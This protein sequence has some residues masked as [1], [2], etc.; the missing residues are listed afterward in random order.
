MAVP[1][2]KINQQTK[3][4]M[5]LIYAT[6]ITFCLCITN[7]YAQTQNTFS[8]SA[9]IIDAQRKPLGSA[10]I[11]LKRATDSV[12]IKTEVSDAEGKFSFEKIQGA[13]YHLIIALM[14]YETYKSTPISLNSDKILPDIQLIE[15]ATSLK[16][17]TISGEKKLVEQ[18]IDR[19]VM[20]VD[21]LISAGGSTAM[22]VLEKAPGV[23]VDQNGSIS[24]KGKN[25][26][27]V[28]IDGKPT[29]LSG[30]DLDTYLRSLSA[31][32]I[33]QIE[34]MTNP[35]AK[36]DAAGNGGVINIKTKKNKVRGFNGGLNLSYIQGVY[37]KSNNSGNFNYRNQ[38]INVFGNLSASANSN[39]SDLDINRYFLNSGPTVSPTFLQNSFIRRTNQSYD[40]K[41][42]LDYYATAN[43]TFGIGFT[44]LLNPSKEKTK[45]VSSLYNANN[46]LDS[47]I[48]ALNNQKRSFENAGV[49]LNFRRQLNK[50]GDE[51][52]ADFDYLNYQTDAD[53]VFDNSSYL[54]NGQLKGA[55]LL[56]GSL[57]AKINIYSAKTD[58]SK[59]FANGY[60]FETGLKASYTETDN[61]ADY[62]MTKKN[63]TRPDYDK[64]NH[65][66]YKEQINAVYV[67]LNKDFKRV[68][69]Q[70][71]LRVEN[72]NSNGHQLGNVQKPDSIFKRDYTGIFP[73]AYI[74]YKLDTIGNQNLNLNY[75]R[76]ID[77][78]YYQSLNP[79][80]SP[81]DKF[82]YY[83]GN[84][85]LRPS[86]SDNIE[87]TYSYKK[88]STS[89][90]Y[91]KAKDQVNETI[92][93]LNGIYYSRPGNLGSTVTKG[94]SVD[95]T[96]DLSKVLSFNFSAR[97][98]NIHT[99][100]KF[101]TGILDT[102]GTFYFGR[103]MFQFKLP[104]DWTAQ[105]DGSYQS[106]VINAQFTAGARGRVN[107]AIAKKLSPSATLRLA[108][109]D[110]FYTFIN[111]GVIN[112]LANT[113][114][115]WRNEGD[116]R[117]VVLSFSYRFG[118]AIADLR[119]H[120]A[121]GAEAE[122]GRVRN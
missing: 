119:K 111:T 96:F 53:Q 24:L 110:L 106:K 100:S 66:I 41:I 83:T 99:V 54:P 2:L 9:R 18:K 36:Y 101:Y 46:A 86:Y 122:Q 69:M 32:T 60:K 65:F 56:T 71:G 58:F 21:A 52:S 84:P 104:K 12:L 39:F 6:L 89:L 17:V 70:L 117:T 68:A 64:T 114:A 25:N 93:I 34:L 80:L 112:N 59:L 4:A 115:N 92:E 91:S 107:L 8:L 74:Q 15:Q 90:S 19:T 50:Q 30:S 95:G 51:L 81:L 1:C 42:G 120:N 43:T 26:V 76:R 31:S 45:N 55:D 73:T 77:R 121:N 14:G 20:N 118:K 28:F 29:Y 67:N 78:P 113:K 87:L 7:T 10:T 22:D 103:G 62:F 49:N 47:S 98:V 57:P 23:L 102:Q 79:F 63:I 61:V 35:P 33:D 40:A 44:G 85:F 13:N 11:Y 48:V 109:N 82:T 94:I 97:A 27:T 75:G 38:N 105:I 116:S 3:H 5:K 88:L 72:T 37:A 108:G 16:G